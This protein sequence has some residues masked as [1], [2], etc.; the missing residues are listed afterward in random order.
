MKIV[1]ISNY[2]THHQK[3]LSDALAE[4][5][6]YTFVSTAE[7]TAERKNMGWG[8]EADPAYVR[9]YI[10]EPEAI[11]RIIEQADVVIAGNA[12]AKLIQSC[13][14]RNQP[15]LRYSER[16]LKK[17]I[18]PLK[19][20]PRF[21]K[22]H[23]Q[24][25]P[26]RKVYM[27][28]ASAFTAGDYAKFGLFREKNFRWGYFPLMKQYED[29][30]A[31]MEGKEKATIL[32]VGRFL[33]WKHPDDA[34]RVAKRLK[35]EG[36]H[37]RLDFI[38][39]GP[40]EETLGRMIQEEDLQDCVRLL[41]TMR[42][43][44]VR[45]HMERAG[46]FLMTSDRREGWGAVVNEAMNSGCGVVVSDA[47]GSAAYLVRDGENGCVYPSENVDVLYEQAKMLLNDPEKTRSMGLDAYRTITELWNGEVAAGRLIML[48]QK[49]LDG[50]NDLNLFP[51]GPV[52]PDAR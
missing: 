14:R 34:I 22:W 17:G 4:R 31:L 15:V 26:W 30:S 21:F 37:F 40:M 44:E 42:P 39:S 1:F 27:L 13:L 18:E 10:K 12:P 47:I 50:E 25:P 11:S 33:E 49:I 3:P 38:G 36:V 41:G 20:L 8:A 9:S 19:F 32:W 52:S 35:S 48:A 43:E 46:V 29:I 6:G 45:S 51:D 24:N 7:M 2:F 28:C 5:C 23:Y 16:P